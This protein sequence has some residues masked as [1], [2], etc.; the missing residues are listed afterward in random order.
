MSALRDVSWAV[1]QGLED[2]LPKWLSDMAGN[3]SLWETL[4]GQISSL[5]TCLLGPTRRP[6]RR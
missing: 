1:P 2:P 6:L 3:S 4:S 5:T